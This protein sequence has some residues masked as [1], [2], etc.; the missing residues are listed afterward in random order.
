MLENIDDVN[1]GVHKRWIYSN[2]VDYELVCD[3]LQ[4]INYSTQDYNH[5]ISQK[6]SRGDVCYLILLVT[7]IQESYIDKLKALDK[8]LARQKKKDY[9]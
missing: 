5:L 3:Y 8:Y 1:S 4:K 9:V 2:K 6:L 7:W